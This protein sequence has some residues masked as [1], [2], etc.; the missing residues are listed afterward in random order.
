M[1]KIK[2]KKKLTD[3][4]NLGEILC[5]KLKKILLKFLKLNLRIIQYFKANK[6]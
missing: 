1:K 2:L 5:Q 3:M 6:V 4:K